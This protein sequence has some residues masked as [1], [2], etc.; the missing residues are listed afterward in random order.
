MLLAVEARWNQQRKLEEMI[1]RLPGIR[2]KISDCR[3]MAGEIVIIV[4]SAFL[5]QIVRRAILLVVMKEENHPNKPQ[6]I[7]ADL[8]SN[9]NEEDLKE[10][11]ENLDRY[12]NLTLRIFARIQTDPETY[13]RFKALTNSGSYHTMGVSAGKKD[14][15][16]DRFRMLPLSS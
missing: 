14:S 3:H 16:F 2:I 7:L 1:S 8:Y 11:E 13:A 12:L 15:H 4:K 10:A 9:L 5:L 6:P